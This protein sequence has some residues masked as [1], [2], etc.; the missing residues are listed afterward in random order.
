MRPICAFWGETLPPFLIMRTHLFFY[1]ACFIA[2]ALAAPPDEGRQAVLRELLYQDCGS[3]H[4]LY[5]S[6]GLG[7][8]LSAQ[9]L[10]NKPLEF[11]AATILVG[12]PAT[13]M[14][15]WSFMLSEEDAL[16]LAAYLKNTENTP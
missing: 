9:A 5:L 4:G 2:P 16:W 11:I 13:P 12:R 8:A 7:P 1:C 14:P 10:E 15:P 3:C 6:G